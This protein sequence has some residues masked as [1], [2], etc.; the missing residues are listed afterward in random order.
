MGEE[1]VVRV[2]GTSITVKV[3]GAEPAPLPFRQHLTGGSLPD[4]GQPLSP[5]STALVIL[6]V[7]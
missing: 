6:L 1:L 3:G 4:P 7:S 5:L 2:R